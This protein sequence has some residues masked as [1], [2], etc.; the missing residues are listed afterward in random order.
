LKSFPYLRGNKAYRHSSE[1][2]VKNARHMR[3]LLYIFSNTS[4][5]VIA[6]F[7]HNLMQ[8]RALD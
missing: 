4:V 6:P 8:K 3:D 1:P 5:E 2:N 7:Y